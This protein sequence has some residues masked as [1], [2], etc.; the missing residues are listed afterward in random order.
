MNRWFRVFIHLMLL[1]SQVRVSQATAADAVPGTTPVGREQI[2]DADFKLMNDLTAADSDAAL[3]TAWKTYESATGLTE[4][5]DTVFDRKPGDI[6]N[7]QAESARVS[8]LAKRMKLYRN[9]LRSILSTADSELDSV[10][11][12]LTEKILPNLPRLSAKNVVVKYCLGYLPLSSE[13][14]LKSKDR[15]R[16]E[17]CADSTAFSMFDLRRAAIDKVIWDEVSRQ[18]DAFLDDSD[19]I[20]SWIWA[21][22]IAAHIVKRHFS[23]LAL[24]RDPG[25]VVLA[26]SPQALQA[27]VKRFRATP[28]KWDFLVALPVNL[29]LAF[30]GAWGDAVIDEQLRAH[31]IE[32]LL[33]MPPSEYQKLIKLTP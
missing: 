13:G 4:G 10:L 12:P 8:S 19:L 7:W 24:Y 5:F 1:V 11:I 25:G 17:L 28:D 20:A 18:S 3:F 9:R 31:S 2:R 33:A 30:V 22:G 32:E 29:M 27:M 23:D 21:H 16:I 15:T 14:P 6:E 26:N